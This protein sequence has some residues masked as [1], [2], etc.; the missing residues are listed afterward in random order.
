MSPL[1]PVGSK[2]KRTVRFS[3][4]H[5]ALCHVDVFMNLIASLVHVCPDNSEHDQPSK[6]SGC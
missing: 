1:S 3:L 5:G 4:S 6:K 2:T